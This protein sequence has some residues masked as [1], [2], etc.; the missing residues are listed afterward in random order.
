MGSGLDLD[1]LIGYKTAIEPPEK[2]KII[3]NDALKLQEKIESYQSMMSKIKQRDAA[4]V[5]Q[6]ST[7]SYVNYPKKK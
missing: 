3:T 6:H 1:A 2:A 4:E 7:P 5:Y